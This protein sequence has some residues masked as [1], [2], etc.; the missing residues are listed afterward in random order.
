[1]QE[2]NN[3]NSQFSLDIHLRLKLRALQIK[4]YYIRMRELEKKNPTVV[5][6]SLDLFKTFQS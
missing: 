6:V 3:F 5:D 2:R 1:M 4:I